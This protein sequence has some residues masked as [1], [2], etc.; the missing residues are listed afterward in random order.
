MSGTA[1]SSE[2]VTVSAGASTDLLQ[3]VLIDTD[4]LCEL[5]PAV[6]LAYHRRDGRRD[7]LT[8]ASRAVLLHLAQAGPVS[9]GDASHHLQR[10]QSVVS[11]IVSQLEGHGL[12]ARE[13]DPSDRR[14]TLVSLTPAGHARLRRDSDVLDR[15]LV[16]RGMSNL[17]DSSVRG[18]ARRA[19]RAGRGRSA[20]VLRSLP[21]QPRKVAGHDRH[22]HD[23][24]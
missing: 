5:F 21:V 15:R 9:V 14:R 18:S 2:T 8:G 16:E 10:A 13:P 24:L 12:L 22:E 19:R 4:A 23:P 1:R 6:Y 20:H 3:D 7:E 11:D 17:P